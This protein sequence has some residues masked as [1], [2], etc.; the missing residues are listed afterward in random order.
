[1]APA[2]RASMFIKGAAGAMRMTTVRWF[3]AMVAVTVT[4][5]SSFVPSRTPMVEMWTRGRGVC[6]RSTKTFPLRLRRSMFPASDLSRKITSISFLPVIMRHKAVPV[7]RCSTEGSETFAIE[8]QGSEAVD[9]SV[10]TGT[11]YREMFPDVL[12]SWLI[13][14]LE[15]CGFSSPTPVQS[16]AISTIVR[17]CK[18]ALVQAYTGSGKTLAFMIPLFAILEQDRLQD[19][20]G[21]RLAG[22][23]I[24]VG[25]PDATLNV[26]SITSDSKVMWVKSSS[27]SED[28]PPR[29][30]DKE[31]G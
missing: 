24:A 12:P 6:A 23:Q 3:L 11:T 15:A 22:V 17:E 31:S 16:A 20:K 9:V 10:A 29:Q 2:A 27:C 8:D 1:M 30:R 25:C 5:S 26:M 14:R 21:R 18:D 28:I 7:L 19:K 4:C 13:D